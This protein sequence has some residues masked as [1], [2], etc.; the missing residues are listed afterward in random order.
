MSD[1]FVTVGHFLNLSNAYLVRSRLEAAGLRTFFPDEHSAL[2]NEGGF[3]GL[4]KSGIRIQV[5]ACDEEEALALIEGDERESVDETVYVPPAEGADEEE[6]NWRE[7][8]GSFGFGVF[9][10]VCFVMIVLKGILWV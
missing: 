6:G 2:A 8:R 1:S 9:A 10:F 3:L 5:A 4:G 7:L